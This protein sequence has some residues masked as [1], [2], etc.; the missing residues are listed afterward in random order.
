MPATSTSQKRPQR[1]ST[2]AYINGLTESE[3]HSSDANF[4]GY[5][6][7]DAAE[8]DY[9]PYLDDEPITSSE[10]LDVMV[11]TYIPQATAALPP[12]ALAH[13]LIVLLKVSNASQAILD[14]PLNHPPE[15]HDDDSS[16]DLGGLSISEGLNYIT[17]E[18]GSEVPNILA[19]GSIN[20]PEIKTFFRKATI[21]IHWVNNRANF[22]EA[23]SSI[24]TAPR[25]QNLQYE[26]PAEYL[27]PI[28]QAIWRRV[29]EPGNQEFRN[30][31]L[32]VV[33]KGLKLQ[34]WKTPHWKATAD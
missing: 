32:V 3:E 9:G 18:L 24:S 5:A 4:V 33:S 13:F 6:E 27:G 14:F 29:Q 7:G 26:I 22:V 1:A 23:R 10:E 30:A 25:Q 28:Q 31:L 34:R 17:A 2:F 20:D 11:E 21:S 12:T 8:Y 15:Q 19:S 16:S